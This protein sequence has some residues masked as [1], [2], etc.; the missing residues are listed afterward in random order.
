[1]KKLRFCILI[2]ALSTINIMAFSHAGAR[3]VSNRAWLQEQRARDLE[4]AKQQKT[5]DVIIWVTMST[6]V[7]ILAGFG[8]CLLMRRKKEA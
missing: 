2:V 5:L 3:A 4:F 8:L 6:P 7:V 1:M